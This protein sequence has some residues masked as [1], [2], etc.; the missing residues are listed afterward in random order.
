MNYLEAG[1]F[2]LGLILGIY[3][4]VIACVLLDRFKR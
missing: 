1:S 3:L 4:G 2:I